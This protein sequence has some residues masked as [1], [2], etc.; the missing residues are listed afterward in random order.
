MT[1][2]IHEFKLSDSYNILITF[3]V[4]DAS[5]SPF[6][7][8]KIELK[9][10]N[11]QIYKL[12]D[13]CIMHTLEILSR[14]FKLAIDNKLKLHE[15]ITKDIGLL[16]NEELHDT[17]G[18]TYENAHGIDYWVGLRNL[19]YSPSGGPSSWLYNK[20]NKVFLEIAPVYRW[21]HTVPKKNIDYIPYDNFVSNY[22][23]DLIIELDK[24]N[25]TTLLNKIDTW[26]TT[27]NKNY[28]L[29]SKKENA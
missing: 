14:V 24:K 9:T 21:H 2:Q 28:Q 16:W 15:S 19:L 17:P 8:A 26:L 11:K 7:D 18:L 1:K 22:Q 12:N 10:P 3:P 20:D 23:P 6:V 13:D 4:I 25:L 5:L 29:M 27:I